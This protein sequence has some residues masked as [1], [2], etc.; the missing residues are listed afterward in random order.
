MKKVV[1]VVI[2]ISAVALAGCGHHES[3][4]ER[5]DKQANENAI[6]NQFSFKPM[7]SHAKPI[8]DFR[9]SGYG[10]APVMPVQTNPQKSG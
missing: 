6:K 4:Q 10:H 9:L 1:Q 5:L 3:R 8:M 2:V 7:V